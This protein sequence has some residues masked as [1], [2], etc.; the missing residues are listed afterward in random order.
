M[1][2]LMI[3]A[4]AAAMIS[5]VQAAAFAPGDCGD[6]LVITDAPCPVMVFKLTASGKT[7]QDVNEGEYKAVTSLKIS[8]GALAFLYNEDCA[9]NG[10]VC[11]Y[12]AASLYAQVK[13]GK[14]T[15]KIAMTDVAIT[16]WSVFGK[17]LDK[18]LAW[19]TDIKKGK[20]VTVK[21]TENKEEKKLKIKSH[22][23]VKFESSD[24]KITTVN[25][26]GKITGVKKGKVTVYA[27]AQN[28]LYK[29]IQVTVK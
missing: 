22:R 7:V 29:K 24:K 27:Y 14:K 10:G 4:A 17:N 5:G 13:V 9:E 25:N 16:K 12:D 2:K 8:K 21:V 11:C 1:K 26:S 15:S 20:S 19:K 18:A 3:A 23:K 28:G 6:D